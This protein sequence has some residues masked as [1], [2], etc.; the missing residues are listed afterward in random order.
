MK[1]SA[2]FA[3]VSLL[4]I[5]APA[6]GQTL[7]KDRQAPRDQ[8]PDSIAQLILRL[9]SQRRAAHLA[10]DAKPLADI[11][12]DDFV[13]IGA[14]GA[15]RTKQQNVDDTRKRI[16][17]WTTLTVTKEQV[18]VFDSTAAL[19]TGEQEGAGTYNGRSFA[20][21]TRYMRVYLKRGGRWQNVAAHASL[22][23]P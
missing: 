13:D 5:S 14:G 19:V 8:A 16:I 18:Q 11:L 17:T 22:I 20:R 2:A 23:A 9:E 1:R 21:R 3:L 10:G 12:A 4:A 15:R 6:K 7:V